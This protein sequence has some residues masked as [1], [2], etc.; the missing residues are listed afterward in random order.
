MVVLFP[1]TQL[2]LFSFEGPWWP[3][4]TYDAA[5][6]VEF[7][8]HVGLNYHFNYITTFR[9]VA[10]LFVTS[11]RWGGWHHVEVHEDDWWILKYESY[12]FQYSPELTSQ[13][14]SWSRNEAGLAPNGNEYNPQHIR[15]SMKVFINPV[16]AQLPE[17]AHLFQ[18]DDFPKKFNVD[19]STVAN[20]QP[21]QLT[22]EMDQKW[23]ERIRRNLSPS[24][25]EKPA[26]K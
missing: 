4:K 14:K 9:K 12:G 26:N 16:V 13:V 22:S 25:R 17:H 10:L 3:E 18:Q 1:E 11:S 19:L 2:L 21:L 20:F 8:E 24:S 23:S 7:L 6:A 15:L 5:W